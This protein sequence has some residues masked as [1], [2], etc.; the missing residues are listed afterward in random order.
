MPRGA[1]ND[2]RLR[3][4]LRL[5]LLRGRSR[6]GVKGSELR[7]ILGSDYNKVLMELNG[8]L[9]KLG[10][11]VKA[12]LKRGE[13]VGLEDKEKLEDAWI[14]IVLSEE[15]VEEDLRSVGWRIDDLAVLAST[16]VLALSLGGKV[17][18][19]N[20]VELLRTKIPEWRIDVA[21]DRF[22]KAGYLFEGEK[23]LIE[24]G[25]RTYMEVDVE[26]LIKM[27]SYR[28]SKNQSA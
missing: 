3:R 1:R 19:K 14:G 26:K 10:L 9:S 21:L 24:L 6:P 17:S 2:P 22:I 8:K 16:I 18:R 27:L 11:R 4:A 15:L 23:D 12:V 25:W 7:K 13:E 20:I 28:P 5:L